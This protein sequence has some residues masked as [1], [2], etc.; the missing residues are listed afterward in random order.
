MHGARD[1]DISSLSRAP[2]FWWVIPAPIEAILEVRQLIATERNVCGIRS[3]TF[4]QSIGMEWRIPFI[5]SAW[6]CRWYRRLV[7]TDCVLTQ[8][9]LVL[10]PWP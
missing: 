4:D 2:Q 10:C 1:F 5:H 9:S 3:P 8:D 6:F 7:G